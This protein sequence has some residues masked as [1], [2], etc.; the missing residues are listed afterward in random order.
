M[1]DNQT[2]FRGYAKVEVMGHQTHFGFVTTEAYGATVMFRIDQPELAEREEVLAQSEY[3]DDGKLPAGSVVKRAKV[4]GVTVLVGAASIYRIIPCTEDAC[5]KAM[6]S[7]VRRP[8]I[9][10]RLPEAAQIAAG[11]AA[12]EPEDEDDEDYDTGGPFDDDPFD[13]E[14][15]GL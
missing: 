10:V 3:T 8:L 5:L 6:E 11:V 9:L 15:R 1:T 12:P 2:E 13:R 7:S 4:N 14:S